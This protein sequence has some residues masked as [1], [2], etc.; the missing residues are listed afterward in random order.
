MHRA[1]ETAGPTRRRRRILA[2]EGMVTPTK[3]IVLRD[4]DHSEVLGPGSRLVPDHP[5]VQMYPSRFVPC[6]PKDAAT[7]PALRSMLTRAVRL[8]RG[9]TTAMTKPPR[10]KSYLPPKSSH[11][12]EP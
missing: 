12:R 11:G 10:A 4:A 5:L 7:R 9:T 2:G 8:G 1:V 3:P 6:D